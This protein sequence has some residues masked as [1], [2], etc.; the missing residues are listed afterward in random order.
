MLR[1]G[2]GNEHSRQKFQPHEQFCGKGWC[3]HVQSKYSFRDSSWGCSFFY[4]VDAAYIAV[5]QSAQS[6]TKTSPE[7]I[8]T[9]HMSQPSLSAEL[10]VRLKF[11]TRVLIAIAF[12]EGISLL[13]S[14]YSGWK[15]SLVPDSPRFRVT[16]SRPAAPQCSEDVLVMEGPNQ[17]E[18]STLRV[19]DQMGCA[20]LPCL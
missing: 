3:G 18:R 12:S 11:L 1:K 14:C 10:F 8:F 7:R 20:S 15:I 4:R 5:A 6:N 19:S 13:S 16:Y 9:L 2:Y 17:R